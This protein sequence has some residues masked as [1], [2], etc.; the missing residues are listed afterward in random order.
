MQCPKCKNEKQKVLYTRPF[1]EETFRKR[2]CQA[3]G[4]KFV[5]YEKAEKKNRKERSYENNPYL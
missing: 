5:T 2:Q 3:C 4:H 1:G